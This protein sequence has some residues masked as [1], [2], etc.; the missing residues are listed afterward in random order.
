MR[1]NSKKKPTPNVISPFHG[2]HNHTNCQTQAME[3]ALTHCKKNSLKLTKIRQQVLEI[4]WESHNPIGAYDVLQKLQERGHKPAPPTAYRALD[5]LVNAQLIHRIES[6]NAFIG[7][8]SPNN[9]HQCQFY[10]CRECNH[11]AE[12]NNQDIANALQAGAQELGFSSQQP[13]IEVHGLCKDCKTKS[14]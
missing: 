2:E 13:I 11:I 14:D 6:L 5:F 7:C 8:P 4:I 1:K 10:I 3:L 12:I 9:S